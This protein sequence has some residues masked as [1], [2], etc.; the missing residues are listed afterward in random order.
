MTTPSFQALK[1]K[2]LRS[3]LF[4][5]WKRHITNPSAVMSLVLSKRI[6][7]LATCH[8]SSANATLPHLNHHNSLQN[9]PL[10]HSTL[11]SQCNRDLVTW[12]QMLSLC[13]VLGSLFSVQIS[14]L[15]SSKPRA[16]H[17]GWGLAPLRPWPT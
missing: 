5:F 11:Y 17:G 16:L 8:H 15:C 4:L 3:L 9:C 10:P 13:S 14:S 12:K 1:P 6:Q 7:N 2:I